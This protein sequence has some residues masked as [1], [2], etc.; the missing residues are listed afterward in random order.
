VIEAS[1]A[2]EIAPEITMIAIGCSSG[3]SRTEELAGP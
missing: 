1:K 3:I 2:R